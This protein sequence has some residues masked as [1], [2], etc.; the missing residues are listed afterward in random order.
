MRIKAGW[1]RE[2]KGQTGAMKL[3][4]DFVSGVG[5]G[6]WEIVAKKTVGISQKGLNRDF[7][8]NPFEFPSWIPCTRCFLPTV[9]H[10]MSPF[11]VEV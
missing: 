3:R 11:F 5:L 4:W 1:S 8:E 6:F 10:G 9:L 2:C 7:T